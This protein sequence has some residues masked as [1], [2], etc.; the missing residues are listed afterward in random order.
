[1]VD[2]VLA[3]PEGT[4]TDA[5]GAGGAASARANTCRCWRNC[6]R[7]VSCAPASTA[8][9]SNWTQPPELD[10]QTQAH[11]SRWW[12]TASRC[13]PTSSSAWRNRSKPPCGLA[14]GL[15]RIA[16]MDDDGHGPRL[17]FS[18]RF[19]CPHCGYSLSELEPRLFSFNNPAGACPDC[20]GL[21]VQAVLRSANAWSRIPQ[22]SL[23]GGAVRGWDRRNAYYFQM[24]QLAG[25][26]LR[27]RHRYPVRGTAAENT[28][29][30]FSTAAASE[31]IEFHY[32]NDRGGISKRQH[33]FEGII[34]NMERRYR[35]TDS[36]VGARGT[37]QIPEPPNP[38]PTARARGCNRERAPC[39]RRRPRPARAS[40]RCRSGEAQ[41]FFDAAATAGAPRRNRRQDREGDPRPPELPGQRGPGLPDAGPQRRR[42]SPAARRSASAWPAR[43]AP[44]WS[45]SCTSWT[46]RPSACTSATTQ[47]LLTTLTHLRD[48]GNTVIVVEHDEDA[49]RSAR[50]RGRHRPRRRRAWRPDRGAGHA[51]RRSSPT[52]STRSPAQYLSGGAGNRRTANGARRIDARRACC[53]LDGATRQQP[54]NGRRWKFPLGL[55][56]CV[57]GVSGS[58]KSTLINDTLYPHRGPRAQRRQR[59]HAAPCRDIEGLDHFDKVVDIDQSPIGRTPRSNPATYTGLFT[60]IRELFAGT[61]E[62]RSRGY[63]PGRFSFN[64]K[65]GRCEACQGDGVIKVEMHFLPDIYVPCD[66]CKGKRYNRE[67]LEVRYKGKNIHE[68]LEM[69]VEDALA[70]FSAV[71]AIARKLQTLMDVGLSYITP[72]PERDHAVRRRSAARQ[73]VAGT[74]QA[75]YRQDSVHPGRADHR[76]ALP[77]HRAVAGGA[78][79]PAR[80]RQHHR[81]HRAQSG[82]H[83]DRRLDHRPGPRGRQRRRRGWWRPARRRRWRERRRSYTGQFLAQVLEPST[84]QNVAETRIGLRTPAPANCMALTQHLTPDQ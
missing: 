42:H 34:P 37:G 52:A 54:A 66:V 18:A 22:L 74:V 45:A 21:G 24:H 55:L 31:V 60:P 77:R 30:S 13:A 57:T 78:A 65:G 38:V 68:V 51:R 29:R 64:V 28:A 19:A 8:R 47:R 33:P 7:R 67:T 83:Q 6:A 79:P 23:A 50:P 56:T 63:R 43:S 12:S 49:I 75:R 61:Q 69:T 2:Q 80:S 40:P 76:P 39:V 26:A 58:G 10:L 9:S 36:N 25:Q 14:D 3:L 53:V 5:A 62:A 4:P 15:A 11:A 48:L 81:G 35:E 41:A 20:D 46:N 59:D 82:C 73:A 84:R 17:L 16:Y 70:F 44:D 72:G 1:M 32:L 71:P 27:L